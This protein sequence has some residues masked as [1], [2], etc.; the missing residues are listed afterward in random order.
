MVA[1]IIQSLRWEEFVN[2]YQEWKNEGMIDGH[3]ESDEW[4][5]V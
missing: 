4:V 3:N 1:D 5:R 2:L